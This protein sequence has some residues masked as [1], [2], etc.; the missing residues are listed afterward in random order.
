MVSKIEDGS[1]RRLVPSH[2]SSLAQAQD[3]N[4]TYPDWQSSRGSGGTQQQA[5]S[6]FGIK[7]RDY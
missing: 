2:P 3:Q 1:G 4:D 5:T 6:L 7:D